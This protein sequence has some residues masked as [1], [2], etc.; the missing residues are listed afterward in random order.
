MKVGD[1]VKVDTSLFPWGKSSGPG[2][3]VA[4]FEPTERNPQ[5]DYRVLLAT[6][7]YQIPYFCLR[8]LT[9]GSQ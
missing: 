6:G 2:M 8:R 9:D 3:I 1:L 7:D 5:T 4:V